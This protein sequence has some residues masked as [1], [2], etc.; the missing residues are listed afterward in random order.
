MF[1]LPDLMHEKGLRISPKNACKEE[2][3]CGGTSGTRQ[4]GVL[5]TFHTQ[6]C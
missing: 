5:L 1:G 2:K 6:S 3:N 4:P